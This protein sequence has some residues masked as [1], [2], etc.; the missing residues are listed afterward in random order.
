ML[1]AVTQAGWFIIDQY[2][3][4][5]DQFIGFPRTRLAPLVE[6]LQ[7]VDRNDVDAAILG[8]VSRLVV[9]F[10]RDEDA[11][12]AVPIASDGLRPFARVADTPTAPP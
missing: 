2:S 11:P 8:G 5:G 4:C 9:D 10:N 3:S 1:I 6:A 7:R 12:G